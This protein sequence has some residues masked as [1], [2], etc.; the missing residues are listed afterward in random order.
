ME[1]Q[2]LVIFLNLEGESDEN[3]HSKFWNIASLWGSYCSRVIL[4]DTK[5]T[6]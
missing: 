6:K 2:V 4:D 5:Q 3:D 1:V